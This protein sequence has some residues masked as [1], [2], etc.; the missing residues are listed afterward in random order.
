MR[1]IKNV[2]S[3]R[4]SSQVQGTVLLAEIQALYKHGLE[5]SMRDESATKLDVFSVCERESVV[6]VL[7][8]SLP[9]LVGSK[10]WKS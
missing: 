5:N 7:I 4:M 10:L 9:R 3:K 2:V 6:L 8:D 1:T